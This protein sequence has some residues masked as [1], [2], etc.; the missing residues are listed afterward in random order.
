MVHVDAAEDVGRSAECDG[1]LPL[2]R[3]SGAG[4]HLPPLVGRGAVVVE[5]GAVVRS[6]VAAQ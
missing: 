2:Q 5:V 1:R 6:D 3:T 4:Q